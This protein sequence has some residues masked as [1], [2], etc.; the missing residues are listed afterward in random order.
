MNKFAALIALICAACTGFAHAANENLGT[1]FKLSTREYS[2]LEQRVCIANYNVKAS[3]IKAYAFSGRAGGDGK[4]ALPERT[5]AYVECESHGQFNGKPMRYIDDCDLVDGEWDCSPPQL[6]IT[7]GING[8]DI[9]VRPWGKLTPE[10]SYLLLKDISRRGHFQGESLDKAIG[11]SCDI[12]QNKDPDII[13]LGCEAAMT[14][15]YWCPQAKTT[16]C[17]RVLFLSFDEPSYIR[18]QYAQ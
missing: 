18:R 13:E 11:N 6:E 2:F 10:K 14:I 8:R 17:P 16:G 4:I 15:S 5:S 12:A 9:N 7:V 3:K 1:P